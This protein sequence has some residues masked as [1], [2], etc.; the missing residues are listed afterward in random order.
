MTAF[1]PDALIFDVDGVL[2]DVRKSFPEMI[3]RTIT[4]LWEKR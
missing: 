1:S 3:R 4:T 2:L